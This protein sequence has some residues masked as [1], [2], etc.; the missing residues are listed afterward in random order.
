MKNKK[1]YSFLARRAASAEQKNKFRLASDD[2]LQAA[3]VARNTE[4]KRWAEA[5]HEYCEEKLFKEGQ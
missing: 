1:D 2:W 5:R 3:D 4:N